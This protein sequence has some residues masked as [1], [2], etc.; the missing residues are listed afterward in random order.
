MA[1]ELDSP[2]MD[3][4]GKVLETRI[5]HQAIGMEFVISIPSV[6]DRQEILRTLILIG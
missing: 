6:T 3:E 4:P 2:G 1:G 5:V